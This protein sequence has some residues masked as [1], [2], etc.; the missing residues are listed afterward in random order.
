MECDSRK[1]D[2]LQLTDLLLGST[3]SLALSEA[4]SE[5]KALIY[6]KLL[7]KTSSGRFKIEINEWTAYK[8]KI[9]GA[10]G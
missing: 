9:R 6:Q 1:K 3:T 2:L 8:G 5:F 10:F 7:S 4:K